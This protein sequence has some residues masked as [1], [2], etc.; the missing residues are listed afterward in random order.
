VNGNYGTG[1]I[2]EHYPTGF[3][4]VKLSSRETAELIACASCIHH[5]TY[6]PPLFLL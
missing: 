4:G 6:D 2:K 1:F 5:A 3:T